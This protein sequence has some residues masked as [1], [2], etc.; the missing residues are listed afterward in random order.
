MWEEHENPQQ[1]ANLH[2]CVEKFGRSL[3]PLFPRIQ[4]NEYE[5]LEARA[6]ELARG[7]E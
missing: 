1:S 5:Y 7:I 4:T 2:G 3:W 6:K